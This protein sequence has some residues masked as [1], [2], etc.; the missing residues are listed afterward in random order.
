MSE[1]SVTAIRAFQREPGGIR[2]SQSR[3]RERYSPSYQCLEL[4][5]ARTIE[6]RHK[7]CEMSVRFSPVHG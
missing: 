2:R 6:I 4:L 7:K 5:W 3:W 1:N